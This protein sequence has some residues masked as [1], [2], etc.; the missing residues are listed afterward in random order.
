MNPHNRIARA[1]V[2]A[3]LA[4]MTSASY[5]GGFGIATQ[6]GSG[7]GNAFAGG[8]AVAEDASTVWYNPAGMTAL[9]GT[10]NFAISAQILKPSFKFQNTGSTLP[11]GTGEGGDG[12]D[13]TYIPHGFV[14]HKLSDKW[15]I[16]A[17]FNTP[18]GLKTQYDAGWR[19]QA[20]ALTSELKT[21]NFNASTAY[22]FND[23]WSVGAGVNYLKVELKFNSQIAIGFVEPNLSDSGIGYN[24]GVLFQPTQNT[25]IGAHY[26]TSI[27]LQ[28]TGTLVAPALIGG[29]GAATAGLSTP[30]TFSLSALHAITPQWEIMGDVTW[31]GWSHVERL[32][33]V[34]TSGVATGTAPVSLTFNWSDTWRTSL[35]VNYKPNAT[36]KFRGGVAY[37][38]TP[39]NDTDRTAR[40]PDQD[41]TWLALGAQMKVSKAGTVDVGYAHEFIKDASVNNAAPITGLRLIGNFKNQVDILSIQ[42]S[43]SF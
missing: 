22:K 28:A 25:R 17:A 12:G 31:T 30:D 19:G 10:T 41:R 36:W 8:A 9:P 4:V 16:G 23:M 1:A 35:G 3:A 2:A 21:F 39:T 38:K 33:V 5:A 40:L 6:N 43:H 11:P 34:R 32:T 13:W 15:S 26:R 37:D 42:Y 24:V 29:T 20:I 18:F 7:T 27:N 14:T